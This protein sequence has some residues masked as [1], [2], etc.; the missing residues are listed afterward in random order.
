MPGEGCSRSAR[1][2]RA[3]SRRGAHGL[4]RAEGP[5]TAHNR[6]QGGHRQPSVGACCGAGSDTVPWPRC[7]GAATQR[8][9]SSGRGRSAVDPLLRR[10]P[11]QC[12]GRNKGAYHKQ[13]DTALLVAV[14]RSL[15]K[16]TGY[17]AACRS[18]F[19][20]GRG[21][22]HAR[23]RLP[24]VRL[25]RWLAPVLP[26]GQPARSRSHCPTSCALRHAGPPALSA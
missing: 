22:R 5:S 13:T 16:Q 25:C 7:G 3:R 11:A 4:H 12:A 9:E 23:R 24:I 10:A 20:S 17:S 26:H 14:M 19:F 1:Y 18:R 21:Q 2:R 15:D 6:A 8:D